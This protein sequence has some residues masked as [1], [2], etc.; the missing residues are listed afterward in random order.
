LYT[1]KAC[2]VDFGFSSS[3]TAIVCLEHMTNQFKEGKIK[4][5]II[6]VTD[7]ILIEKGTP[8]QVI[9]ACWNIHKKYGFMNVWFYCDASNVGMIRQMKIR[10]DENLYWKKVEDVH[11]HNNRITPVAFQNTHKQMLSHLHLIASGGYLAIYQYAKLIRP[12]VRLIAIL[13]SVIIVHFSKS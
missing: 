6:R 4:E 10:W 13:V 1:A 3:G 11:T 12:I 2:G 5:D 8:D 9:D 7:C